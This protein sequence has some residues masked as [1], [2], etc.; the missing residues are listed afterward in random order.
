MQK[1]SERVPGKIKSNGSIFLSAGEN[2]IKSRH[3]ERIKHPPFLI[4]NM[5]DLLMTGPNS[6]VNQKS[7]IFDR[8][9]TIG[10]FTQLSSGSRLGYSSVSTFLGRDNSATTEPRLPKRTRGKKTNQPITGVR[11]ANNSSPPPRR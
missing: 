1:V 4:D 11:Q 5:H 2:F 8:A 9:F 7:P 6:P 10:T 3:K